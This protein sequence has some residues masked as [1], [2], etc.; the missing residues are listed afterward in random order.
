MNQSIRERSIEPENLPDGWGHFIEQITGIVMRSDV[1]RTNR[2]EMS[3]QRET[4]RRRGRWTLLY[5]V[6][7][8]STD[9]LEEGI[10]R[11]EVR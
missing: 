6:Q 9:N 5:F 10:S 7:K 4:E 2:L 1:Q 11:I 8:I 3:H